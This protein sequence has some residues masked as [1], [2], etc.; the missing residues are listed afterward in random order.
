[1]LFPTI[2]TSL[3]PTR[4]IGDLVLHAP[5]PTRARQRK[6]APH[7]DSSNDPLPRSCPLRSVCVTFSNQ[8]M[9]PKHEG[10]REI[11]SVAERKAFAW[12]LFPAPL[13]DVAAVSTLQLRMIRDLAN[14]YGIPYKRSVARSIVVTLVGG[15]L[16]TTLGSIFAYSIVKRIS[17]FGP[18]VGAAVIPSSVGGATRL[19]GILM[20]QHFELGGTLEDFD[21]QTIPKGLRRHVASQ[22]QAANEAQEASTAG[23]VSESDIAANTGESPSNTVDTKPTPACEDLTII[24]GIGKKIQSLLQAESIHT[25]E[26]LASTA[27]EDLQ[28]ILTAAGSRYHIHDPTTWPKQAH[29]AAAQQWDELRELQSTLN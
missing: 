5:A 9:T 4:K 15:F 28:A 8:T 6:N 24:L 23:E 26:A 19:I 3:A 27:V 2:Q 14:L 21:L 12:G 22:A 25:F 11:V 29:L 17:W 18:L 10:A 20:T 7:D 13:V 16:P 1:M